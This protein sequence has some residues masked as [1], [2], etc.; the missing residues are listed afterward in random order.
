MPGLGPDQPI[1]LKHDSRARRFKGAVRE[2]LPVL[3]IPRG[4]RKDDVLRALN[5]LSSWFEQA[6]KKVEGQKRFL[7]E[8]HILLLGHL[9]PLLPMPDQKVP[10]LLSE[11]GLQV[12]AQEMKTAES[13]AL[14][15][16]Y[17]QAEMELHAALANWTQQMNLKPRQ[18]RIS[19][20]FSK[21]GSCTKFGDLSFSWRQIM[22]PS[23]ILQYLVVH[24][25]SHIRNPHHQA[26]F[27]NE[28]DA[29]CPYW[30]SADAWLGSKG[31][32]LMNLYPRQSLAWLKKAK[33]QPRIDSAQ[34]EPFVKLLTL[35]GK[36]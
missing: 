26:S 17:R 15:W 21:W 34:L 35:K 9:I 3:V 18:V 23:E 14:C 2:G 27:W 5:E 28:V 11:S 36:A 4:A 32:M 6:V 16:L 8:G 22:A 20:T 30:K 7:P 12:A 19:E 13:L 24:E 10:F 1:F 29:F 33:P 25:L 31:S